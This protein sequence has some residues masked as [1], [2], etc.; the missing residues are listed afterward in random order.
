MVEA[1]RSN[2]KRYLTFISCRRVLR[3]DVNCLLKI[4][5]FLVREGIINYGLSPDGNY[6]FKGLSLPQ[7]SELGKK[8]QGC[9]KKVPEHSELD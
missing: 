8:P 2:P 4:Y 3:G 5:Q 6:N 9:L 7:M 1:Y